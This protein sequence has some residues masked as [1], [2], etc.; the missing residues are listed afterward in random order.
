M[1]TTLRI[2]RST[3]GTD[4]PEHTEICLIGLAGPAMGMRRV[5]TSAAY[6]IGRGEDVEIMLDDPNTSRRHATLERDGDTYRIVDLDSTNGTWVQS[7]RI[8][9][10]RL[11]DDGCLLR[12]GDSVLKYTRASV[13]EGRYYDEMFR[14][15]NT[16]GLTGAWNRR[17]LEH[18]LVRELSRAKRHGR[19]LSV[20]MMDLDHFKK[21]N[22]VHGHRAGDIVL[23]TVA[24]RVMHSL[25][26][27]DALARYGGEEF[28]VLLPETDL[29]AAVGVAERLRSMVKE[30]IPVDD[31][32]LVV[33]ASF[34]VADWREVD[35]D[36][37]KDDVFE[38]LATAVLGTADA[39]LYAAKVHGR[40]RVISTNVPTL[41]T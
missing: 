7:E 40:D 27:E 25:R 32:T 21:V 34:G 36:G 3:A 11:L 15:T 18:N 22:D 39:R 24:R 20:I 10:P 12:I 1:T 28:V 17:Y 19:P 5:L 16:D 30:P 23:A 31:E 9:G 13:V 4:I 6:D 35:E 33:S 2:V 14:R 8:D 38:G 29:G 37:L 41:T 26:R